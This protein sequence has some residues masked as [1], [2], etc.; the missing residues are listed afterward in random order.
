MNLTRVAWRHRIELQLPER[1][2]FLQLVIAREQHLRQAWV[3]GQL[4]LDT[5]LESKQNPPAHFLRL[6]YPPSATVEIELLTAGPEA[7]TVAAIT[8]H[9]LPDVLT[10]PFLGNWPDEAQSLFYGPRAQNVQEIM[11]GEAVP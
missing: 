10:S 3:D 2:T 5:S 4:A 8:W 9:D 7:F 1:T 6:V 11:V